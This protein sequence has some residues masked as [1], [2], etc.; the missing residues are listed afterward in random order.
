MMMTSHEKR[1]IQVGSITIV[2]VIIAIVASM[3]IVS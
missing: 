1:L 2:V 3:L